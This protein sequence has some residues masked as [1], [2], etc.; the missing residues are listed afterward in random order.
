MCV[1]RP[2]CPP[3]VGLVG[4][5]LNRLGCTCIWRSTSARIG[6]PLEWKRMYFA[7]TL[8][9]FTVYMKPKMG[10]PHWKVTNGGLGVGGGP[11]SRL[12]AIAGRPDGGAHHICSVSQRIFVVSPVN[13]VFRVIVGSADLESSSLVPPPVL[14]PRLALFGRAEA[15]LARLIV[16]SL[17]LKS[18]RTNPSAMGSRQ[19]SIAGSPPVTTEAMPTPMPTA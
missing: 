3:E 2:G 6:I 1:L 9:R 18:K 17:G 19:R 5:W 13:V 8:V 4:S 16:M 14:V 7:L 15:L 12:A 10:G 11:S